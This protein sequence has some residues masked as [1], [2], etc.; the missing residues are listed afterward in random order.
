MYIS[1]FDLFLDI[2]PYTDSV[3]VSEQ[4]INSISPTG[5]MKFD[6]FLEVSGVY[7]LK[8]L[9]LIVNH[10][11]HLRKATLTLDLTNERL[12]I[13]LYLKFTPQS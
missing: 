4:G 5:I 12:R 11:V 13:L 2:C 9:A 7:S 10:G 3:F 6:R 1:Y 8:I